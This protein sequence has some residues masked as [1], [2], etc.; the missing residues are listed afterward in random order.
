MSTGVISRPCYSGMKATCPHACAAFKG[1]PARLPKARPG[2]AAHPLSSA[3]PDRPRAPDL[4]DSY[5]PQQFQLNPKRAP[6][7]TCV[8]VCETCPVSDAVTAGAK[9][10]FVSTACVPSP[11]NTWEF[12][13]KYNDVRGFVFCAACT[14][15]R[16][17]QQP[18][19]CL[20]LA[21]TAAAAGGIDCRCPARGD[22][23]KP[24]ICVWCRS[25]KTTGT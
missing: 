16:G 21:A 13:I 18:R 4:Q 17:W 3:I 11:L 19:L 20:L 7:G 12:V 2:C 10:V 15:L 22:A 6:S 1:L 8:E 5:T 9:H 14:L 25:K 24:P 23:L